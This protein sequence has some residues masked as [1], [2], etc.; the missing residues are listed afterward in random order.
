[1]IFTITEHIEDAQRGKNEAYRKSL[2]FENVS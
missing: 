1:M 2:V